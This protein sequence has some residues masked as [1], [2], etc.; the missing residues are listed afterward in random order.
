M[1]FS[2]TLPWQREKTLFHYVRGGDVGQS[3][4]FPSSLCVSC[5]VDRMGGCC[6][7]PPID[8]EP[9]ASNLPTTISD[10]WWRCTHALPN[11]GPGPAQRR[12]QR[13]QQQQQQQLWFAASDY[14]KLWMTVRCCSTSSFI[15]ERAGE[16]GSYSLQ[17]TNELYYSSFRR[18]IEIIEGNGS[19]TKLNGL[20]TSSSLCV[21]SST[22]CTMHQHPPPSCGLI[23]YYH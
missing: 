1:C 9:H 2:S 21:S 3:P 14:V 11:P 18:R 10:F 5:D 4:S 23:I 20:I 16:R 19:R 13:Q 17:T 7:A 8:S 12:R 6:S 15:W 22:L